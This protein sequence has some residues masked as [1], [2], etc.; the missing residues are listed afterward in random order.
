MSELLILDFRFII[1]IREGILNTVHWLYPLPSGRSWWF[2]C[3]E[4]GALGAGVLLGVIM[5][6][7]E[8]D[9]EASSVTV[10]PETAGQSSVLKEETSIRC[11]DDDDVMIIGD[12]SYIFR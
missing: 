3:G 11:D 6:F 8:L 1:Y 2:C 9:S 4:P 12:S 5:E 10:T 7:G